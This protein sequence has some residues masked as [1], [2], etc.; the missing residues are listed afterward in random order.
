[1]TLMLMCAKTLLLTPRLTCI[2]ETPAGECLYVRKTGV[3]PRREP[4]NPAR[5]YV[6]KCI[7]THM[8]TDMCTY[9][10]DASTSTYVCFGV[11]EES[12][13]S[14]GTLVGSYMLKCAGPTTSSE[15]CDPRIGKTSVDCLRQLAL[16]Q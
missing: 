2:L 4:K 9:F 1:M 11:W 12:G 6:C 8:R 14:L 10:M 7:C 16:Q 13:G 15:R 5:V 3:G